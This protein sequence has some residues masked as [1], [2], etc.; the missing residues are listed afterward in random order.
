[1]SGCNPVDKTTAGVGIDGLRI[2]LF[3]KADVQQL[4]DEEINDQ[5]AAVFE[6]PIYLK[7]SYEA[8]DY[9]LV[10]NGLFEEVDVAF[11]KVNGEWMTF[12]G[13]LE[14]TRFPSPVKDFAEYSRLQD[15]ML[16]LYLDNASRDDARQAMVDRKFAI[17]LQ[18]SQ[19]DA[20]RR[21]FTLKPV[22]T[23]LGC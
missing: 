5:E 12:R 9:L 14:P 3:A 23:E 13:I 10:I 22:V 17:T 15:L 18:G 2:E 16:N 20:P 21:K 1:M 19:N 8:D 11:M 6:C 7:S 4:I